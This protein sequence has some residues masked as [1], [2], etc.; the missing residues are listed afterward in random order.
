MSFG[1]RSKGYEWTID[2][3]QTLDYMAPHIGVGS[4]NGVLLDDPWKHDTTIYFDVDDDTGAVI[5]TI[6]LLFEVYTNETPFGGLAKV[7][8]VEHKHIEDAFYA[9]YFKCYDKNFDLPNSHK[10][11]LQGSKWVSQE[12]E[13]S[14]ITWGS[15]RWGDAPR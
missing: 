11:V 12:E 9:E 4:K 14:T 5:P 3:E 8:R 1:K 13:R 7:T 10:F 2:G 15:Q 6:G